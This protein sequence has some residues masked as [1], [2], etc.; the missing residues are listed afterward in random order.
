MSLACY[1]FRFVRRLGLARSSGR[2]EAVGSF[3]L[4]ASVLGVNDEL[5]GFVGASFSNAGF[6]GFFLGLERSEIL[7]APAL[8]VPTGPT[9]GDD[10]ITDSAARFGFRGRWTVKEE[11]R[12][13]QVDSDR[14]PVN[15]DTVPDQAV[16]GQ[17]VGVGLG[18][19]GK[20]VEG[21]GQGSAVLEFDSERCFCD[22]DGSR[23]DV[24]LILHGSAFF[25]E[26]TFLS[27]R[28]Y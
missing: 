6:D 3:F 2:V 26:G 17:L 22:R 28:L 20:P 15:S 8:Q 24:R 10:V 11:A 5:A 1:F 16:V 13:G 9:G 18:Q 7:F 12:N 23:S 4:E 25:G 14:L 19:V 21:D 27:K